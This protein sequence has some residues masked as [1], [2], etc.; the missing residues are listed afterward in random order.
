MS[1]IN[2]N[3]IVG[4]T[5]TNAPYFPYG[6]DVTGIGMSVT[7]GIDVT[8]VVTATQFVGDGSG[9]TGVSAVGSGIE[10]RDSGSTVGA[11]ATVDF[12]T[13]LDVSPV[14]AGVVTVT[15]SGGG[16]GIT[17]DNISADTLVVTG[18]ST[19]NG[20]VE[21]PDGQ[22][23][24]MGDGLDDS[25]NFKLYNG[26]NEPFEIIGFSKETYIRNTGSN[27][28]G[29]SISANGSITLGGGGTGDFSVH[30]NSDGTARLYSSGPSEKLRTTTTGVTITGALSVS[31]GTNLDGYKIE[32]GDIDA[33]AALNGTFNF[34]LGD[35][36]ILKYTTATNGNYGPNIRISGTTSLDS[37][38]DVGDVVTA[39]LMVASSTHYL[40]GTD[41]QIDGSTLNLD[42]DY[43]GGSAP[44]SA[45][46]SGYDIYSFTIQKTAAEGPA[47][48]IIV[49]TL[50]AN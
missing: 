49:N 36:H 14:S 48:H 22:H 30:A 20:N 19:F 9:L 11:A 33:V 27:A 3:K 35:G 23:F 46:G 18:V 2:V 34:D 41:I 26:A 1:E 38:T 17:T 50:G 43:V 21:L 12:S 8:G 10:V 6:L 45:N 7:G 40:D 39:T 32:E 31:D 28:N 15:A 13:G 4:A 42:I 25:G 47:Y 44:S 37:V 5:Q 16:S 29:I 24:I